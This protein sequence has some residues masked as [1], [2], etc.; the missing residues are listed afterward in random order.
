[1]QIGSGRFFWLS[2]ISFER[3]I[4]SDATS[5]DDGVADR[6]FVDKGGF[7]SIRIRSVKGLRHMVSNQCAIRS[8]CEAGNRRAANRPCIHPHLRG[9]RNHD[10][11]RRRSWRGLC[12][13]GTVL[14]KKIIT[15]FRLVKIQGTLR[16]APRKPW[17]PNLSKSASYVRFQGNFLCVHRGSASSPIHRRALEYVR[18]RS[19]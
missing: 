1:M 13:G 7:R 4:P 9:R 17:K 3:N 12:P 10:P 18:H 14:E 2:F 8:V 6:Q 5:G 15:F 11:T 19:A 16:S